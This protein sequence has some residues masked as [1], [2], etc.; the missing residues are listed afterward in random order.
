MAA[1]GWFQKNASRR[2]GE[3]IP[4]LFSISTIYGG[5]KGL[6]YSFVIFT[7]PG[8]NMSTC[9]YFSDGTNFGM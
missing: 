9:E 3:R 8:K 5:F 1:I 4:N 6:L 2:K 7:P